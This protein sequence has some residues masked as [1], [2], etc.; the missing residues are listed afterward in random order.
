V[1]TSAHSAANLRPTSPR[2]ALINL[3]LIHRENEWQPYHEA[4]TEWMNQGRTSGKAILKQARTGVTA[5][6]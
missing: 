4:W 5:F 1:Q 2:Q 3:G 6:H